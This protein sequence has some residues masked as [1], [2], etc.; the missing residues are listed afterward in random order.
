MA[1]ADGCHG[2]GTDDQCSQRTGIPMPR[3]TTVRRRQASLP[4]SDPF[5]ATLGGFDEGR[6][7][8]LLQRRP[9]LADPPPLDLADVLRRS[10]SPSSVYRAV[11]HLDELAVL[12]VRAVMASGGT[13][14]PAQ[15]AELLGLAADDGAVDRAIAAAEGLLLV[16]LDAAGTVCA[17]PVLARVLPADELGPPVAELLDELAVDELRWVARRRTSGVQASRKADLVAGL[18]AALADPDGIRRTVAQAPPQAAALA[19]GLVWHGPRVQCHVSGLYPRYATGRTAEPADP[20][21]WLAWHGLVVKDGWYGCVMPREVA[22]ALRGG[23]LFGDVEVERP[24]L[25]VASS[26]EPGGDSDALAAAAALVGQVEALVEALGVEPAPLLKT[27]GLGVRQVRRLAKAVGTTDERAGLVIELA[28]AA[29]LVGCT[30]APWDGTGEALPTPDYDAWCEQDPASRWAEL[31]AAWLATESFPSA[32]LSKGE[33]GKALPALS[34]TASAPEATSQRRVVLRLLADL[35][36][37]AAPARDALTAAVRWETPLAAAAGPLD[38]AGHVAWVLA[39]AG[40]LGLVHRDALSILG[41][42]VAS[43][44]LAAAAA[45]LRRHAGQMSTDLVLQADLTAIA[46]AVAPRRFRE[47]LGLVA[48]VESKGATVVYRFGDGSVRRGFDA[49][50][51]AADILDFL[52]EHATTPVP[53]PLT[54]LVHDV[55]RRHG[56]IRVGAACCYVRCADEASATEVLRARRTAKLGLRAVSPTV[57]VSPEQPEVVVEALQAAGYLPAHED[58]AGELVVARPQPRRAAPSARRRRR[59]IAVVDR[60]VAAATARRLLAGEAPAPTELGSAQRSSAQRGL[61]QQSS[62]QRGSAQRGS[63]LADD[64]SVDTRVLRPDAV[65]RGRSRSESDRSAPVPLPGVLVQAARRAG[66]D[67]HE[68]LEL[69]RLVSGDADGDGPGGTADL[70]LMLSMLEGGLFGDME[71]EGLLGLG[72]CDCRRPSDIARSADQIQVLLH[73]AMAHEWTVRVA[74]SRS[75]GTQ[76]DS[77]FA[78]VEDIE[79]DDVTLWRHDRETDLETTV[80]SVAWARVLTDAEEHALFSE[81]AER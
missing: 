52:Q 58:A 49:G 55:A 35:P 6:L 69:L 14:R 60:D 59:P 2:T 46:P 12:A 43:A 40:A 72:T 54:Y 15:V 38:P 81:G 27:G 5:A 31:V 11:D 17:Q 39:E 4:A 9:D 61:A 7:A 48:D 78:E 77:F 64:H 30:G 8:A 63:A 79:G 68:V 65:Q 80:A 21:Q 47:R 20:V 36:D 3:T 73:D 50:L 23:L 26:T 1:A 28:A 22:L 57:L 67:E 18:A 51:S 41:R 76:P 70:A 71:A 10:A 19:E 42:H 56:S 66:L 74:L 25:A 34:D 32:A 24:V 37:G 45:E 13:A 16:A 53:Q 62:A 75:R 33:D 29:G 44:D